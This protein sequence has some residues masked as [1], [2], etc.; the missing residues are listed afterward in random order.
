MTPDEYATLATEHLT[1]CPIC[2]TAQRLPVASQDRA[3]FPATSYCCLGCGLVY[4]SPRMSAASYAEFYRSGAYRKIGERFNGG[5]PEAYAESMVNAQRSYA[6]AA[7]I[8]YRPELQGRQG[9]T[10][11]DVGGS[12]GTIA[13]A[14]C[15]AFC[16][17]G[18]VLEPSD[19]ERAEAEAKGLRTIAGT[20]DDWAPDDRYNV[21]TMFQTID[22]LSNP[23]AAF[24]KLRQVVG[25]LLIFDAV[26][27]RYLATGL[28]QL[29]KAVKID[30]P[31]AYSAFTVE[32]LLARTGFEIVRCGKWGD[33]TKPGAIKIAEQRDGVEHVLYEDTFLRKVCFVCQPCEPKK[34]WAAPQHIRGLVELIRERQKEHA[35][36]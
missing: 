11:L 22:H 3:D 30:H 35:P 15:G 10:L 19:T 33:P 23:I 34:A 24:E 12:N 25:E 9:Q 16:M 18:T 21:V 31:C 20:L 17:A 7:V 36:A 29:G 27:F 1:A 14:I 8:A 32:V 4:I 6:E 5:T 28:N 2:E 13:E 26:E